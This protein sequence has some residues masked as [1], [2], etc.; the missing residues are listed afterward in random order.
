VFALPTQFF[1]D[2]DGV[3][4]FVVQGPLSAEA[5]AERVEAILPTEGPPPSQ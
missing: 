3:I 5:A 2:P 4:R 1:I